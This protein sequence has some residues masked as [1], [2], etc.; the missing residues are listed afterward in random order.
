M[1]S[2]TDMHAPDGLRGGGVHGWTLMNLKEFTEESLMT[3]LKRKRTNII[4]SKI[5]Y[6]D[7]GIH[8]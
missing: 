6:L 5:P 4:Y 3:E 2:G 1:I 7:P 8:K